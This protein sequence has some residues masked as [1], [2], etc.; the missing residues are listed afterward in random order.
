MGMP[1]PALLDFPNNQ[2][3]ATTTRTEI[4]ERFES[5]F[6]LIFRPVRLICLATGFRE[7]EEINVPMLAEELLDRQTGDVKG[8]SLGRCHTAPQQLS[9]RPKR[10]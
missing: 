9:R 3:F 8:L 6:S 1:R 5:S 4:P 7:G 2:Q 10:G